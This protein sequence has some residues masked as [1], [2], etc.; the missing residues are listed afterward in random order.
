M[1][2]LSSTA[3]PPLTFTKVGEQSQKLRASGAKIG[4]LT[5]LADQPGAKYD[6]TIKDALGRV[7]LSKKNCG[8][9]TQ[10]YGELI[11]LGTM[12]GEELQVEVE[13]IRGAE[14]VDL[15]LN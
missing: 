7:K 8:N 9:E 6:L 5:S 14:K 10:K 1:K 13:N 3:M 2:P 11:N 15:F 12:I 4:W